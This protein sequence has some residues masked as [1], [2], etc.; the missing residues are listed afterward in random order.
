M[1]RGRREGQASAD[2]CGPP[3]KK[4]QAA[5]TTGAAEDARPSLRDALHVS[6]VLSLGIG[7]LASIARASRHSITRELDLSVERPGPHDFTSAPCRSSAQAKGLRCGMSRPPLPAP[8]V[9][10]IA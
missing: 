7:F 4:M 9:V 3:A 5:G 1:C 8:R 6:F 2:A 10:T